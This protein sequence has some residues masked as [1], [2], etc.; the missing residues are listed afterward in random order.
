MPILCIMFSCKGVMK[1]GCDE[2]CTSAGGTWCLVW[3]TLQL[4]AHVCLCNAVPT[5]RMED[6]ATLSLPYLIVACKLFEAYGA[7]R[8]MTVADDWWRC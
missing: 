2:A 5:T 3:G 4:L 1:P 7:L 8:E 6:M